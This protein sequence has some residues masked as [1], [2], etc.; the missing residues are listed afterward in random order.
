MD[1]ETITKGG[2]CWFEFSI[3]RG[4]SH[5]EPTR[6]LE[7]FIRTDPRVE[8]LFSGLS[9]DNHPDRLTDP[10]T[11]YSPHW[12][13]LGPNPIQ[14]YRVGNGPQGSDYTFDEVGNP[15]G[16]HPKTGKMN[17][18]FLKFVG[19]SNPA[20]I[21]FEVTGPFSRQFILDLRRDIGPPMRN[22]ARDYVTPIHVNLRI[23]SQDL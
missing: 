9:K 2:V 20:G 18:S 1:I 6:G 7:I 11:D 8:N 21:T 12:R 23:S 10:L 3:K 19:I 13:V 22:F 14:V 16:K 15:I 4:F 5:T 17:L